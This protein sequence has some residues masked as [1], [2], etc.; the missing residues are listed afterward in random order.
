MTTKTHRHVDVE[1]L[2]AALDAVEP[3]PYDAIDAAPIRALAGLVAERETY[4]KEID[5]LNDDIAEAVAQVRAAG[6]SWTYVALAL[7]VSRQAARQK[8]GPL[9]ED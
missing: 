3:K 8:Y 6:L 1:A 4:A 7:G 9:V 2:E 5:A